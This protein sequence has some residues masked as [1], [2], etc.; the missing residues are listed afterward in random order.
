MLSVAEAAREL[1]VSPARVRKLIA[2]GA[3]PASKAGRAWVLRE[4]D[5]MD[6]LSAHV[7]A[8]RPKR[9]NVVVGA[10]SRDSTVEGDGS[11]SELR[12]YNEASARAHELYRACKETFRF[13]PDPALIRAAKSSEEASFYM[14]VADFFLQQKQREL[15]AQGVF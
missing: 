10:A 4:E 5:V 13:I 2:D 6:R 8:G 7:R 3:L 14:A 9:A 12:E 11:S 1:G 15:V